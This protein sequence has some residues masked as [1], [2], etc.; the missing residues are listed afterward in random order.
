MKRSQRVIL[1]ALAALLLVAG[2][3]AWRWKSIFRA[4]CT[5][6]VRAD[7]IALPYCDRVEL[8][9]LDGDTH[10]DISG[11]FPVRPYGGYSRIISTKTLTGADAEALAALWRLQTFA[12]EYQALC[13]SPA[14]G[15][16]FYRGTSLRFE[17]S[18]CYHCS[19]FYVTALGESGWWGFDAAAPKAQDLLHRLQEIFPAS[20]PKP[21]DEKKKA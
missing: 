9:H 16:R 18:V 11:G 15:F 21:R 8:Y 6:R 1:I 17:T 10:R 3:C 13:H 14:Y 20:I 7:T 2:L 4:Y 12:R 5:Y 19:N